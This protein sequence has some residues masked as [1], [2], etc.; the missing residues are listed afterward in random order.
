MFRNHE[1][2]LIVYF[3]IGFHACKLEGRISMSLTTRKITKAPGTFL[4][5]I[6]T[7]LTNHSL[8][9]WKVQFNS[10]FHILKFLYLELTWFPNELPPAFN[11]SNYV[12]WC[13]LH[14]A[15]KLSLLQLIVALQYLTKFEVG[16]SLNYLLY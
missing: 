8:T 16:L 6:H 7:G 9:L 2:L 10:P 5:Q 12:R 1:I 14:F 11:F 15:C 4:A 3:F 13:P